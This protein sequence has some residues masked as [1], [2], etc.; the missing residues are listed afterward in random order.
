MLLRSLLRHAKS[1]RGLTL[2]ADSFFSVDDPFTAEAL[3]KDSMAEPYPI[4]RIHLAEIGAEECRLDV[5]MFGSLSDGK[6]GAERSMK[7]LTEHLRLA[8]YAVLMNDMDGLDRALMASRISTKAVIIQSGYCLPHNVDYLRAHFPNAKVVQYAQFLGGM[9]VNWGRYDAV[10]CNSE[11]TLKWVRDN[12][13]G[14]PAGVQK[15]IL[16]PVRARVEK[17]EAKYILAMDGNKHKGSEIIAKIAAAMPDKDFVVGHNLNEE[18]HWPS[19]VKHVEWTMKPADLYAGAEAVLCLSQFEETYCRVA[20]EAIA[21]GIPVVISPNGNLP[22]FR[23]DFPEYVTSVPDKSKIEEYVNAI[24]SAKQGLAP[25]ES[26]WK[27]DISGVGTLLKGLG[28]EPC[29]ERAAIAFYPHGGYGDILMTLPAVW[30]LS[31]T[32]DVFLDPRTDDKAKCIMKLCPAVRDELPPD[33]TMV[34]EISPWGQDEPDSILGTEFRQDSI[35]RRLG[36]TLHEIHPRIS[37]SPDVLRNVVRRIPGRSERKRIGVGVW[38]GAAVKTMP[39]ASGR[40]LVGALAGVYD[41]CLFNIC[42]TLG[43][44]DHVWDFGGKFHITEAIHALALMDCC[45]VVDTGIAHFAGA[46]CPRMLV[47]LGAVGDNCHID[48]PRGYPHCK[49]KTLC[50]HLPCQ[51]C[52]IHATY[53]CNENPR[54]LEFSPAEVM[55]EVEALCR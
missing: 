37:L 29:R 41:V 32:T 51:P 54:C 8:G 46:V 5:L 33:R 26:L 4:A 13:C 12:G 9:D 11:F 2:P 39:E 30:E 24:R 22:N 48:Y 27:P 20:A 7:L 50:K 31:K 35:A 3:I 10:L 23:R 1:W 43:D 28:I 18:V 38:A 16:D 34:K 47:L 49:V 42:Q 52:W 45:V 40:A 36:V 55:P 17:R 14:K 53:K 6:G 25:V 21:N 19:N 15:P 44:S